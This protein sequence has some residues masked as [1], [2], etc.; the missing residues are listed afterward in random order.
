MKLSSNIGDNGNS[1]WIIEQSG[2]EVKIIEFETDCS[3][4]FFVML[5]QRI[6]LDF[7]TFLA[8]LKYAIDI[9][10]QFARIAQ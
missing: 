2:I 3:C 9:L 10:V 6:V 5:D 4:G 1:R 8:A 7:G